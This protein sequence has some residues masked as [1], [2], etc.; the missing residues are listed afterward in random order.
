M[1]IVES[2]TTGKEGLLPQGW[3]QAE[4]PQRLW[5]CKH[6]H[7]EEEGLW[8]GYR[9]T[10][11]LLMLTDIHRHEAEAGWTLVPKPSNNGSESRE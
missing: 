11:E 4:T 1:N 9:T 6:L 5:K 3:T 8:G 2:E 10:Q 7:V